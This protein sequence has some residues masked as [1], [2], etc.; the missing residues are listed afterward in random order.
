MQVDREESILSSIENMAVRMR[1]E[2]S[3]LSAR[4]DLNT[5]ES[6]MRIEQMI[7]DADVAVKEALESIEGTRKDTIA[8]VERI[9]ENIGKS[10]EEMDKKVD[11][12][13]SAVR[14]MTTVAVF[15][16]SVV[17]LAMVVVFFSLFMRI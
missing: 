8:A 13:H 9:E 14:T 1:E 16:F 5:K 4:I 7:S 2:R 11:L 12:S 15:G 3:D 6:E 10:F 17:T